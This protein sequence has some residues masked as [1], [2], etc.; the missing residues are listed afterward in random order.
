MNCAYHEQSPAVTVCT[1]CGKPLCDACAIHWEDKITCKHCLQ[2]SA[3]SE[4]RDEARLRK[5]PLLAGLLSLLPGAGQIYVGHYTSG[6]INVLIVGALISILN[7]NIEPLE[8]FLGLFLSFFWIFNVIDAV[9][10]AKLYNEFMAGRELQRVPTDSPLIAGIVLLILGA[11]LTLDITLGI[12]VEFLE[13]IWPL[14]VLALGIYFIWKYA[15]TR[16]E[17]TRPRTPHSPDGPS[18]EA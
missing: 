12:S 6:F 11:L 13:P 18:T 3:L 16:R 4:R 15:R 9:R 8:P 14:A 1:H 7:R 2:G 17:L 10:R 5:S